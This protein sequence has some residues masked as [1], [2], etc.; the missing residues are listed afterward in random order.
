MVYV[1][2]DFTLNPPCYE[3]RRQ[4][5]RVP[6]RPKVFQVLTYLIE[7]RHR[8]VSREELLTHVW[9]AQCV[10]EEVLT[11]CIKAAR[12]ALGDSGQRQGM[13]QTVHGHGLRFVADV[14]VTASVLAPPAEPVGPLRASVVPPLQPLA[15]RTAELTRL[16]Q[17]YT[18]ACQGQRQ[19][20]FI[21]GEAGIGK[22]ALV[23][24]FVAQVG[25]RAE[26]CIG[27][28]QCLEQ[29][30]PG[31]AYRPILEALSRLCRGPEGR[32]FLTWLRQH[33][34]SWLAQMPAL[35]ADPDRHTF[36][37]QA[38]GLTPARMLRE[39]AEALEALTAER[40]LLLLLEDVHWSDVATLE[41]LAYVARRR[42]PARLL[43]LS[44]SR[45]GEASPEAH[46]CSTATR[47]L[48]GRGLA[49]EQRLGALAQPEV[50]AYATQRFGEGT[51]ATELAPLLYQQTQGHPLF[52]VT[53]VE[54]LIQRGVLREGTAGWECTAALDAATVGVP[55][56]LQR[57]IERQLERL[58]P[59][60]QAI[61]E[62]ASAVGEEFCAAAVAA[63]VGLD[64]KEV[65]TCCTS[66]ARRG[67][68]MSAH[69]STIWPDGTVTGQYR[70]RHTLY[71]AVAQ[72]RLPVGNRLRLHQQIAWQ[73]ER[74]AALPERLK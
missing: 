29:H 17:W 26:V 52:L 63:G 1:F 56:V 11:S 43:V 65:D 40:P 45:L 72:A 4:G 48:L 37:P 50:A 64:A 44:T 47:D 15:G 54:D 58:A 35:L 74:S 66:L 55:E 73:R 16:H 62:A 32:H 2:G 67:Q 10:N 21:T 31:E 34:P 41:W 36:A 33:A 18:A 19:V 59:A 20:A 7:Q 12:R 68:F 60:E 51:L 28:G 25:S 42:D 24:T 27:H 6:L 22:T 71:Q 57:L 61:V 70:F 46:R 13:I 49:A 30:G 53:M 9:S 38:Q 3:L 8:V 5:T 14:T 69:G 39:L 23:E